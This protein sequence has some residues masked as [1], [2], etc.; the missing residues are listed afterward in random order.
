VRVYTPANLEFGLKAAAASFLEAE[1]TVGDDGVELS[2]LLLW[3][4]SDFGDTQAAVLA[5]VASFMRPDS[6]KRAAL[7]RM[8]A[9][10][11][12]A[13]MPLTAT[14]WNA[15][16]GLALPCFMRCGPINVR[17][18]AYDWSLNQTD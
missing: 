12:D 7:E 15:G 16:V 10:T 5:K 8:L 17:Y 1:T 3:Y 18:A 4:G 14:L 11:A 6:A 9:D 13:P 2:S